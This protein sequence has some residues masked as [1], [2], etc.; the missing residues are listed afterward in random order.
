MRTTS[1]TTKW[2][3]T[4]RFSRRTDVG[5]AIIAPPRAA[6]SQHGAAILRATC[7]RATNPNARQAQRAN[8]H[9]KQ[10]DGGALPRTPP[11]GFALWTLTRDSCPW[12]LRGITFCCTNV[13]DSNRATHWLQARS[14]RGGEFAPPMPPGS[15]SRA[16]ER[17]PKFGRSFARALRA[18]THSG[19]IPTEQ[20]RIQLGQRAQ[21]SPTG[22]ARAT[23]P[24]A[25]RKLYDRHG[26]RCKPCTRSDL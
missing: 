17:S 20:N 13:R 15:S 23:T 24:T 19:S 12:T 11:K 22:G 6:R 9:A 10:G 5:T 4:V 7:A 18:Q 25:R 3:N 1:Q 2:R 21:Q 26:M 16:A 8:L 14:F